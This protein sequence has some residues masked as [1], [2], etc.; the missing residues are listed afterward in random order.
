ME[1][2]SGCTRD[3]HFKRAVRGMAHCFSDVAIAKSVPPWQGSTSKESGY[4]QSRMSVQVVE[5]IHKVA[6]LWR[7]AKE[8]AEE[9]FSGQRIHQDSL[10]SFVAAI[11]VGR[12]PK[13]NLPVHLIPKA[14][15][16][17]TDLYMHDGFSYTTNSRTPKMTYLTCRHCRTCQAR[18]RLSKDGIFYL[19]SV[20][21]CH[22]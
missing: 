10:V 14:T 18:A 15:K 16:Q 9:Y 13:G 19:S 12:D 5:V 3:T 7:Y 6:G 21:T 20:H 11:V 1:N 17:K 22:E 8:T 4:S 2:L